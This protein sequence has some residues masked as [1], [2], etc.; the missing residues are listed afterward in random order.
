MLH[1]PCENVELHMIIALLTCVIPHMKHHAYVKLQLDCT[2]LYK[3]RSIR[4][5]LMDCSKIHVLHKCF[6]VYRQKI[7]PLLTHRTVG[8]V[9]AYLNCHVYIVFVVV[10]TPIGGLSPIATCLFVCSG[11]LI[12]TSYYF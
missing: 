7:K 12:V 2:I 5:I 6:F 1:K 11:W 4:K 3:I 10:F 9:L 8:I